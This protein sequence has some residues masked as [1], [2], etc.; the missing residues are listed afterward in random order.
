MKILIATTADK[1]GMGG[2]PTYVRNLESGLRQAGIDAVAA[3][4]HYAGNVH[5]EITAIDYVKHIADI[6]SLG[7]RRGL[8]SLLCTNRFCRAL[9]SKLAEFDLIHA[10]D[11]FI[12][13][14]LNKTLEGKPLVI[15]VHGLNYEHSLENFSAQRG[16]KRMAKLLSGYLFLITRKIKYY[17]YLGLHCANRVICVDNNYASKIIR[18]GIS[19]S[20]ITV[21]HNAVDV[22]M[23]KRL[24]RHESIH[25]SGR[26]YFLMLRRFAP[27]NGVEFGV[28]GFL[29]WVGQKD[30]ELALAGDGPLK[31]RLQS[32]C[33]S[34]KNG[35]KVIF[36]GEVNHEKTPALIKNA[37]AT[38]VPS[39]PVGGVVEAT[40][41]AALESLAL[42]V[43]V[44]ASNIGGLAE[45]DQGKGIMHLVPPGSAREISTAMEDIYQ[46][47]VTNMIDR[48]QLKAHILEN[49]DT[50]IW[51]RRIVEVYEKALQ[52]R[53]AS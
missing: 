30:V 8:I 49:Y 52:A 22:E 21:I 37:V 13:L 10:Q 42:G 34:H 40:S 46:R 53:K 6:Y 18:G 11:P 44:I 23:L 7:D 48:E 16:F 19:P 14:L 43:P 25:K 32:I 38:I 26:P 31:D 1:N 28:K 17:E 45:I 9:Q 20:K 29:E 47:F 3:D 35:A 27:K 41:L 12:G 50:K 5:Y 15:T 4:C 36:L 2:I 39:V 33:L 51:I 24:S